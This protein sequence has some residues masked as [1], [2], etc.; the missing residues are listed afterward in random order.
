MFSIG[1]DYGRSPDAGLYANEWIFPPPVPPVGEW[2]CMLHVRVFVDVTNDHSGRGRVPVRT[3][4]GEKFT[5][6]VGVPG[7]GLV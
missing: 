7:G 4:F 2:H 3:L 1:V 5:R 6:R